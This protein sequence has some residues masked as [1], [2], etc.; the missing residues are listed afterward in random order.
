MDSLLELSLQIL[1]GL[2]ELV[3]QGLLLLHLSSLNLKLDLN[4]LQ[5][6]SFLA[7]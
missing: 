4:L 1:V 6:L 7:L 5:L 2:P 3:N